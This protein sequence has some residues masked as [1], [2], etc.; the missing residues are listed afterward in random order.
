MKLLLDTHTF[1]WWISE[2]SRLSERA[3]LAIANPRNI[4][5]VSAIS[6][7]EIAIK[8]A[9]GKLSPSEYPER[10]LETCRFRELP[11]K[12]THA[13]AL[14]NLPAI[15]KDPFDRILVAQAQVEQ[16][17]LVSHDNVLKSYAVPFLAA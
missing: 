3:R 8:Q 12:I 5:F 7:I 9:Q 16:L 11:L 6:V 17:M 15:H 2:K 4:V 10:L 14:R 13:A 1:I